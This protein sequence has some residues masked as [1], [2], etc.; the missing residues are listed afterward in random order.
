MTSVALQIEA[1]VKEDAFMFRVAGVTA[2]L[3]DGRKVEVSTDLT[4]SCVIA[5]VTAS[6][7]KS[8]RRYVL[9]AQAIG[10]AVLAVEE[11]MRTLRCK[12][13]KP[14]GE[15]V[16]GCGWQGTDAITYA[17]PG[18]DGKTRCCPVCRSEELVPVPMDR[19]TM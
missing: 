7:K 2:D 19:A 9:S 4:G 17:L 1:E 3:E 15:R 11:N 14:S 6:N 13:F 12:K 5:T 10:Q 18:I 16:D 8:W